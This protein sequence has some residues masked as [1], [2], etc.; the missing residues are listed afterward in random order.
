MADAQE[1]RVAMAQAARLGG[2]SA[3][4]SDRFFLPFFVVAAVAVAGLPFFL[5][6]GPETGAEMRGRPVPAG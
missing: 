5:R 3:L 1:F 6:L 4:T 2:A